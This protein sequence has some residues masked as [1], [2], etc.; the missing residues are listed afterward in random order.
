MFT[1]C[2]ITGWKFWK[3]LRCLLDFCSLLVHTEAKRSV[4]LYREVLSIRGTM[5]NVPVTRRSCVVCFLV[6]LLAR[7]L[8]LTYRQHVNRLSIH[9]LV[10]ER[11]FHATYVLNRLF[12]RFS[13]SFNIVWIRTMQ[14]R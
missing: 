5:G 6:L 2:S 3:Q 10:Y 7:R 12:R 13:S 4:T 11:N 9:I 8:R 1:C 14:T